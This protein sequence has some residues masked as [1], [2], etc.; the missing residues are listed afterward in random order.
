MNDSAQYI[1]FILGMLLIAAIAGMSFNRP[2]WARTYTSFLRYATSAS[3]FI[4]LQVLIYYFVSLLAQYVAHSVAANSQT[5]LALFSPTLISVAVTVL[6]AQHTL[7]D[8]T[9]RDKLHSLAGVPEVALKLTQAL[10]DAPFNAKEQETQEAKLLLLRRGIDCDQDWL[11]PAQASQELFLKATI[12]YLRIK[13]WEQQHR[14]SG[15]MTEVRHDFDRMRDRFDRLSLKFSRTFSQI[16]ELG[17]IKRIATTVGLEKLASTGIDVEQCDAKLKKV[18]NDILGDLHE[19]ISAFHRAV[20]RLLARRTLSCYLTADDRRRQLRDYGY[21]LAVDVPSPAYQVFTYAAVVLLASISLFFAM[22]ARLPNV[23][24]SVP[25]LVVLITVIQLGALAIAIVPKLFWGFANAGIAK[26][27]PVLF[28][29]GAG[30]AATLFSVLVN[31]VF[32]LLQMQ[33]WLGVVE[34]LRE[35]RPYL[36][37][38]FATAAAMA[39]LVQDHRWGFSQSHVVRR[40]CDATL[41]GVVWL[42]VSLG[43]TLLNPIPIQ[44]PATGSSNILINALFGFAVGFALGY[45]V[46]G[47]FRQTHSVVPR[48][49]GTDDLRLPQLQSVRRLL[50]RSS[51]VMAHHDAVDAHSIGIAKE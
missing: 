6:I 9:L 45:I 32:G 14:F 7:I 50:R 43:S 37:S 33:G 31:C 4:F 18:I 48:L 12:V 46:P 44:A 21:E 47:S 5:P 38:A 22:A 16:E 26:R 23:T 41:M 8:Q 36:P 42:V 39:F 27:T 1:R 11:V 25:A 30:L 24:L 10:V 51:A 35:S 13:E 3:L 17:D 29:L 15:F 2:S 34:R 40:F 19:D 28:V 49:L 20:C